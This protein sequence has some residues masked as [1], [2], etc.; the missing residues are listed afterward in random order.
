MEQQGLDDRDSLLYKISV[1][2][3]G[4]AKLSTTL[5]LGFGVHVYGRLGLGL[6][7]NQPMSAY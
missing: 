4:R 3:V 5:T 2:N 6:F 1:Q 7:K